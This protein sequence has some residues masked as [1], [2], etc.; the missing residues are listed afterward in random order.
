LQAAQ[1]ANEAKLKKSLHKQQTEKVDLERLERSI[2]RVQGE[3]RNIKRREQDL[4]GKL[5]DTRK[6]VRGAQERLKVRKAGMALR[7]REMYKRGRRNMLEILFS[8]SSFSGAFRRIR[9]LV[10]IAEQDREEYRALRSGQR[11]VQKLYALQDTEYK[12]QKALLQKRITTERQL[13]QSAVGKKQAIKRLQSDIAARKRAHQAFEKKKAESN[14]RI[15][16]IL[17]VLEERQLRGQRLAELPP[18]DFIGHKGSLLRPVDGP[19]VTRYGKY[20]DPELKTW[21]FN[22]G[23]NI[24]AAEGKNVKTVAPGEVV[25]VDWFPGYG[26]FVLLRHPQGF[27]TLYGHLSENLVDK[28]EI[29][30]EGAVLGLVGNSGRPDGNFWL[31][32]EI[33]QGEDPEDPMG[34]LVR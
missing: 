9:Y 6:Q 34:W 10:R 2:Y 28:G 16:Q 4:S 25:L 26:L 12:H 20:Q 3:L 5:S 7:V 31:H 11:R 29:L 14:D 33:M 19:V 17:K 24:A 30:A 1:E 15:S 32:F 27:F 8:S 23:I 21:T 22:R 13:D 18:F